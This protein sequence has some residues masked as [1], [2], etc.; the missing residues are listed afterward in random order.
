M[1]IDS[2]K[3]EMGK[4]ALIKFFF[5]IFILLNIF[6]FLNY[7]K[8]DIDFFKKLLSWSLIGY[9]FYR[10][11]FTKII[12]GKKLKKF[13]LLF[14]LGFSL[15]SLT[16][17]LI[18]Y[19]KTNVINSGL[20][21]IF[22][23]FLEQVA[24]VTPS[25]LIQVNFILGLL[26]I[27]ICC[28]AILMNYS[29]E[30]NSFIGS[31]NVKKGF[32]KFPIELIF[33]LIMSI[34]FGLIVF[35]F[36]MEW[37]A[38]AVDS[39]ILVLG[40]IYYS[41]EYIKHH[42]NTKFDSILSLISNTG[43]SFYQGVIQMFSNKKTLFIGLSFLLTLHAIVDTGVYLVPYSI[44]TNSSLYF[45]ALETQQ[46]VHTP[47]FNFFSPQ[48][49][50]IGE[51]LQNIDYFSVKTASVFI[52]FDILFLFFVLMAFPFFAYYK[53]IQKVHLNLPKAFV[54]IFLSSLVTWIFLLL[55]PSINP[56]IN[57]GFPQTDSISGVDIYTNNLSANQ[58]SNLF[59]ASVLK[60][61]LFFIIST[62]IFWYV[63]KRWYIPL[64]KIM[65][66]TTL[67]F[68]VIYISMYYLSTVKVE[69]KNF[70]ED[71]KFSKENVKDANYFGIYNL[72]LSNLSMKTQRAIDV[73]ID[74]KETRIKI[75]PFWTGTHKSHQ[76]YLVI[77]FENL[78]KTG[79]FFF[80][81]VKE[82]YFDNEQS[83]DEKKGKFSTSNAKGIFVLE[84]KTFQFE[85]NKLNSKKLNLFLS[86][87][88][89]VDSP[90]KT[91]LSK[92]E[93][94]V[95]YLRL[96]FLSVFY[97]FGTIS[98]VWFFLRKNVFNKNDIIP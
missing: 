60:V 7:I 98:F 97:I 11:S 75:H 89:S 37:F 58:D 45:S 72:Y 20:Y 70:Q 74:K 49:S 96:I 61:L 82:Y 65:Y 55:S 33:F 24:E 48:K 23:F 28:V 81:G 6:D 26:L 13:D 91:T 56:S 52:H 90:E 62:L 77:D 84:N 25:L 95:G 35:N 3:K 2:D 47:I 4:K 79:T 68:F 92:L 59:S 46:R 5:I 1:E 80:N 44:G 39:I 83:Y 64:K 36:F 19:T 22:G 9:M 12:I 32:F 57:F 14:I 85:N 8:G 40:L 41:V 31:I 51:D 10:A 53:N 17:A 69:V 50:R 18:L 43:N 71:L 76:D 16:K 86:N 21:P 29:V 38:L 30:K 94:A 67:F 34:F 88:I 42:T 63:K 15:I 54:V 73:K 93:K 66:F 87:L 78:D 27:V